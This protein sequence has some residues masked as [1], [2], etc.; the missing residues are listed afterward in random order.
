MHTRVKGE[1]ASAILPQCGCQTGRSSSVC[2]A[3]AERTWMPRQPP[4][5]VEGQNGSMRANCLS[6]LLGL[7]LSQVA[8]ASQPPPPQSIAPVPTNPAPLPPLPRSSIAAVVLHR[9]ELGLTDEQVGEMEQRDQQRERENAVVREE[10]EKKNQK[11]AS[12]SSSGSGSGSG[13]GTQ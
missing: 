10:M 1:S 3:P 11:G 4:L 2:A 6:F 8:C 13:G 7:A 12:A 9:A 5:P